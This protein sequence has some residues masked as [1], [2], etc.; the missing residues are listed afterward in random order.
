[1]A[2]HKTWKNAWLQSVGAYSVSVE[3]RYDIDGWS[4]M[5]T[6]ACLDVE[7]LQSLVWTPLEPRATSS[8][9]DDLPVPLWLL[10]SPLSADILYQRSIWADAPSAEHYKASIIGIQP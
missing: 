3:N 5:G 4:K 6:G 10:R 8:G 7:M 9:R 1:M 2:V